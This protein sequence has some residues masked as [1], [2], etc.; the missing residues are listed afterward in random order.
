LI[1][2]ACSEQKR[3]ANQ[4]KRDQRDPH[5][6]KL[7]ARER[8]QQH[9]AILLG[10]VL[11][12]L[13][14]DAN[15]SRG[16]TDAII[17]WPLEATGIAKLIDHDEIVRLRTRDENRRLGSHT[18]AALVIVINGAFIGCKTNECPICQSVDP[19]STRWLVQFLFAETLTG[20]PNWMCEEWAFKV[21][22][23]E[24]ALHSLLGVLPPMSCSCLKGFCRNLKEPE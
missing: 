1:R 6:Q 24:C 13:F 9:P 8:H 23:Y 21:V 17:A 2:Q 19:L 12:R 11:R 3:H 4:P 22:M 7:E 10:D 16:A 5:A 15:C 14:F 20:E 18:R